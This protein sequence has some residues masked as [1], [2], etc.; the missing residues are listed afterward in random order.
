MGLG[1]TM[2]SLR[3]TYWVLASLTFLV[4]AATA[5]SCPEYCRCY[6]TWIQCLEPNTVT[7]VSL[8]H[9]VENVTEL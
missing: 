6:S 9:N 5:T 3:P 8:F 1:T 4:T 2:D 7:N